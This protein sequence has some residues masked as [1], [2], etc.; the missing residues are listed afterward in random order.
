MTN[1]YADPCIE[2]TGGTDG[3]LDAIDGAT[4]SDKCFAITVNST[5]AYIHQLDE[6]SGASES[7]PDVIAPDTN[8]GLKRWILKSAYNNQSASAVNIV[9]RGDASGFDQSGL[10]ADGNW[11]DLDLSATLP[12]G[13]KAALLYVQL[14]DDTV[15]TYVSFRKKGNTNTYNVS[16]VRAQVAGATIDADIIVFV[17]TDRIFQY[18][19]N[20]SITTVNIIVKG[21]FI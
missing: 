8:A 18:L 4:V 15:G 13:T 1:Y 14:S 16:T 2:L 9:D 10:T 12:E 20:S 11:H 7:S 19:C 6:D 17:D 3:A 21:W 5:M